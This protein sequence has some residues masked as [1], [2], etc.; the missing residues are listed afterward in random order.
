M[1]KVII[2]FVNLQLVFGGRHIGATEIYATN[3]IDSSL[4]PL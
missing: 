3:T 4:S 2:I 1:C